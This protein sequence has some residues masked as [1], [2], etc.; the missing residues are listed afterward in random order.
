MFLILYQ[1][2]NFLIEYFVYIFIGIPASFF[3]NVSNAGAGLIGVEMTSS[4]GG[5][6]ENYEVEEC[7][8]GNYMVITCL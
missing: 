5:A 4:E 1:L 8:D 3:I 7:G 2:S 6:V